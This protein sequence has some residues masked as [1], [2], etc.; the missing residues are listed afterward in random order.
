M[1]KT[2]TKSKGIFKGVAVGFAF[3]MCSA[4]FPT[5]LVANAVNYTTANDA[6]LNTSRI[7]I[8]GQNKSMSVKKGETVTIPAGE[9]KYKTESGKQGTLTIGESVNEDNTVITS[10]VNVYYTATNDKVTTIGNTFAAERVGR[11]TIVYEVVHNG[12]PYSY[13]LVVTSTASEASFEFEQNSANIIPSVYDIALADNKDIVLPLPTVNDKD[14][15][16]ILTSSD[17]DF[18]TLNKSSIEDSSKGGFVEISLANGETEISIEER[19]NAE[20]KKE[21]YISGESLANQNGREFK[22]FYSYYQI[23]ESGNVFVGSTSK[24]FSVKD[25]YYYTTSDKDTTGYALETSFSSSVSSL[26]AVVG[27]EKDLPKVTAT[28]KSTNSPASES[29]EVYYEVKVYKRDT[30]DDVTSQVITSEGKFKAK[31]EGSYRFVYTVKD[32]YG[33]TA[34]ESTTSFYIYNV[35]DSVQASVYIYDAGNENAYDEENNKYTSADYMMKTQTVN[36][37]IVMYAVGG[38]DNM[39]EKSEL[40]L[41]REIRDA[42]G[43]TKFKI[44]EQEYAGYNLIFAPSTASGSS[45]SLYKQIVDD[46]YQIYKQMVI[47]NADYSDD[48]A[49]IAFLKSH[50]YLLVTTEFNKDVEGNEIVAGLT[51]DDEDAVTKMIRK[52]ADGIGYAYVKPENKNSVSFTDQTYSFYYYASDNINTERSTYVSVKVT[53]GFS[54]E[55]IPTISFSSDLQVAYLPTD[56]F[57]FKVATATDSIDSKLETV[58]AY[59]YLDSAKSPIAST[60]TTQTLEYVVTRANDTSKY[61]SSIGKHT[62]EGWYRDDSES[63][64]S[65]DLTNKP[66]TAKYVEILCYAIDDYGNAGFFNRIIKIADA[67]DND[68]PELYKI[69]NAP[70]D[71]YETSD[72]IT[73]PTLYF[74]DANSNYMSASVSVYKLSRS[75][76]DVTKSVMKSTNMTTE[77]DTISESFK[78]SGGT[79]H[80]STSGEYQVAITVKDSANHIVTT[81]FTYNVTG[82]A[83]YVEPEISN[84]T[85]NTVELSAGQSYHLVPPTIALVEDEN[86]GYIGIDDTDDSYT[87]T[88]YT[89]SA[90]SATGEYELDQYYFTAKEEGTYK[91]K[92]TVY[93]MRYSKNA[94]TEESEATNGSVYL[95]NGKLMFK[96]DDKDYVVRIDRE[97][98]NVLSANTTAQGT[99]DELREDG[100]NALENIVTVYAKDSE[101][102]TIKVGGV[103]FSIGIDDRTYPTEL[104]EL[105]SEV[106]IVKPDSIVYNAEGYQTNTA[107]STVTITRTFGGVTR[108]L[109]QISLEEW[110]NGIDTSSSVRDDF[111]IENGKIYLKL[112]DNG[113]YT[114]KYSIQAQDKNGTNVGSAETSEYTIKNGDI[115]GPTVELK[116]SLIETKY[117]VGDTLTLNMSGITVSDNFTSDTD[118]L[119]KKM[120]VSIKNNDLDESSIILENSADEDGKYVYSTKLDTAGNYTLTITVEDEAGNVTTQTMSFEVTS[121]GSS[122]VD[123]QEVM[124]GVLIGLSVAILAGVVIYFIVSK[125]KLDKKENSYKADKEGK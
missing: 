123:V 6:Q 37:N 31:E 98:G 70:E 91:I 83:V 38:T 46:N 60:Q 82:A 121:E 62:L 2:K 1:S 18:Y 12:T 104:K 55:T 92:Y 27:V 96:Y 59:R 114:I 63:T 3:V 67:E 88:Y 116:D 34:S 44:S 99:G 19:T 7:Q 58:T 25:N 119:L 9:Y 22:I 77:Y 47:E 80:A 90:I 118:E 23:G 48:D 17:I 74:A 112:N 124:G 26:S 54:D 110:E 81:Y 72:I 73:L 122:S 33:N 68:I 75:G 8:D 125:V 36:R 32:F 115:E 4:F 51:E 52:D 95:K 53:S 10:S 113:K 66:S 24:T 35:K 107:D 84:I 14:G 40:S 102:Q 109:A 101:V 5:S 50:N 61:Y 30:G 89:T 45:T 20:G 57:D 111:R 117:S 43:I 97:N 15:E 69:V 64:Y 71:N 76:S 86:Y 39:V 28:T 13:E 106:E 49:I 56:S 78:V 87:A 42:S 103:E 85:S 108:T 29:V 100:L 21:F 120:T 41:R 79:F 11:Y 93:L 94:L 16:A 105:G 65:V